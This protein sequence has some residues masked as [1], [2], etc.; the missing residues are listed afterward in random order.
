VPT[1]YSGLEALLTY[2]YD[3]ALAINIFDQNSYILKVSLFAN[4]CAP[5]RNADTLK[6]P[7][8]IS[9]GGPTGPQLIQRCAAWLG[10]HQ[11]GVTTPDPTAGPRAAA[12]G[13][14]A[15]RGR[16]GAPNVSAGAQPAPGTPTT[17]GPPSTGAPSGKAPPIDL[18]RTLGQL[19]GTLPNLPPVPKLPKA[20]GV[21]SQAPSSKQGAE[22]LLNYLL[23]P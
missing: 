13:R 4:E 23:A 17:N 22:A 14:A 10:P 12:P 3:N 15:T 9:P 8:P 7:N 6:N 2:V 5:Y 11:P 16:R 21:P 20:P 18:K 19:L 1:G